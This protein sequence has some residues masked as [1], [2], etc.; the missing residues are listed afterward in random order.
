MLKY[1]I[2]KYILDYNFHLYIFF[3]R[4][5]CEY[6]FNK[7]C[8]Y[9]FIFETILDVDNSILSERNK[10]C[11]PYSL[12]VRNHERKNPVDTYLF[13]LT[14]F[15]KSTEY[16]PLGLIKTISRIRAIFSM[17][18]HLPDTLVI[19]TLTRFYQN[20]GTVLLLCWKPCS[21]LIKA[22]QCF[23]DSLAEFCRHAYLVVP[24]AF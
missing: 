11:H 13:V 21:I 7:N 23:A 2:Y 12:S 18:Y 14:L 6:L 8:A 15:G 10:G 9:S 4:F 19:R 22:L 24:K 17:L 16:L 3:I 1:N 5:F 20:F